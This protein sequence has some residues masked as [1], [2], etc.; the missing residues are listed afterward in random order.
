MYAYANELLLG[1][2]TLVGKALSFTYELFSSFFL[3]IHY[4]AL[5]RRVVDGHQIYSGGSVVGKASTICIEISPTL[6]LILTGQKVQNLA[7]FSFSTSLK[8][9]PLAFENAPRYPNSETKV[10]CCDDRPRPMSSPSLVKLG[11][12]TP[13][14]PPP[15]YRMAKTC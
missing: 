7:S 4:I 1:H 2:L 14:P 5:N 12:R 9:E 6:P 8:F 15:Q 3:S 10:Q 11:P 13:T